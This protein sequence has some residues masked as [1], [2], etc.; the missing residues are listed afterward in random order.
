MR[1]ALAGGG[2]VVLL[3]FG[4]EQFEADGIERGGVAAEIEAGV[5]PGILRPEGRAAGVAGNER[6]GEIEDKFAADFRAREQFG[7]GGVGALAK[8]FEAADVVGQA[9]GHVVDAS[10]DAGGFVIHEDGGVDEFGDGLGEELGEVGPGAERFRLT[11]VEIAPDEFADE[12]VVDERGGIPAGPA[13]DG[14][15]RQVG[16]T[17][18][19]EFLR[20]AVEDVDLVGGDPGVVE[21]GDEGVEDGLMGDVAGGGE[22]ADFDADDVGAGEEVPPGSGFVGLA[23]EGLEAGGDHVVD[24]VGMDRQ[25]GDRRG[26]ADE[27][28][29]VSGMGGGREEAENEEHAVHARMMAGGWGNCKRAGQADGHGWDIEGR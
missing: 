24:P 18:V 25:A 14:S 7:D 19:A 28:H 6:V 11:E 10:G 17:G 21:A 22:G 23:G 13:N 4:V 9:E 12:I 8:L 26:V 3:A 29:A 2:E 20:V 5:G 15:G 16:V 1:G 27:D